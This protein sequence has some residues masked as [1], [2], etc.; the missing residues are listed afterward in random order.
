[1]NKKEKALADKEVELYKKEEILRIDQELVSRERGNWESINKARE[2]RR[3]AEVEEGIKVALLQAKKE[4]LIE[5]AAIK[6]SQIDLLKGLLTEAI[7]ALQT[8]KTAA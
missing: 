5:V 2:E 1:M 7:K 3:K 6:D 8:I 4:T